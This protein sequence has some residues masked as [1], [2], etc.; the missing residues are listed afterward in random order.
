MLEVS[1]MTSSST[2]R[3]VDVSHARA[4]VDTQIAANHKGQARHIDT[5]AHS[6]LSQAGLVP[7]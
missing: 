1:L 3:C 4:L 7:G 5:V 6:P 2:M